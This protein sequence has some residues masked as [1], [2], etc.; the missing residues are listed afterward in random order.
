MQRPEGRVEEAWAHSRKPKEDRV[1]RP[2]CSANS[3]SWPQGR[4]PKRLGQG[5]PCRPRA[6]ISSHDNRQAAWHKQ[7]QTAHGIWAA[8]E[9][10]QLKKYRLET[11]WPREDTLEEPCNVCPMTASELETA[12][13]YNGE[14]LRDPFPFGA[15][16]VV[17]HAPQASMACLSIVNMSLMFASWKRGSYSQVSMS[18]AWQHAALNYGN[19]DPSA[20]GKPVKPH[21]GLPLTLVAYCLLRALQASWSARG[22]QFVGLCVCSSS[23]TQEWV[24]SSALLVWQGNSPDG[25]ALRL[26][27]LLSDK[28]KVELGNVER[29]HIKTDVATLA[30]FAFLCDIF[31]ATELNYKEQDKM[32]FQS[33]S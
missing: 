26:G 19:C 21:N 6:Y 16:A 5:I 9:L 20:A 32:N 7:Q 24:E 22:S 13:F 1:K 14:Q 30:A 11:R 25:V 10:L 18:Y 33:I 17:P 27:V 8:Q 12:W 15:C 4:L 29:M 28:P 3:L 23:M 2:A 31:Y